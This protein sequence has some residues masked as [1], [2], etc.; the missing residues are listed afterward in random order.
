MTD[1]EKRPESHTPL[2]KTILTEAFPIEI[3]PAAE[4]AAKTLLRWSTCISDHDIDRF[5]VRVHKQ[6]IHVPSRLYFAKISTPFGSSQ[7]IHKL[8]QQ[9][10]WTRS[11]DGYQRQAALRNILNA[12][13]S[14]TIPF[15]VFLVGEYV[16][17]IL[18]DI[19]SGLPEIDPLVLG[20]FLIENLAFHRLTQDRVMSYWNVCYR[21]SFSRREY[22]GFKILDQF[23]QAIATFEAAASDHL[24]S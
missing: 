18:D 11:H 12:N 24:T 6:A 15:V 1:P 20:G 8:I 13:E 17:E 14:W 3:R 16:I 5:S 7:N 22:V 23:K 10:I 9:C 2:N 4:G 21:R 19:H